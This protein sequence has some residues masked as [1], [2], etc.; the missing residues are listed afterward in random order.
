MPAL[1]ATWGRQGPALATQTSNSNTRLVIIG[2]LVL[3]VGVI[4]VLA[5]LRGSIA[6]DDPVPP[7][8][9]ATGEASGQESEPEDE[10]PDLVTDDETSTARLDLPVDLEDGHEAVTVRASFARGL[11]ALPAAGDR[12]VVYQLG[13]A[14]EVD[15]EEDEDAEAGP[16]PEGDAERVLAD[17]EVLGVIGPRP[18]ANDG[19]LTFVLAV[20]E[21]EVPG[22]LPIARDAELWL[23]LLPG[24]EGGAGGEDDEL[25]AGGEDV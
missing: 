14:E 1:D 4:L 15:D 13:D 5:I 7:E 3:F 24:D 9:T 19:T 8:T 25:D 17:V 22:L 16:A 6:G 18:A 2:A 23:T 20:E 10:R 21:D 12:V 11:A